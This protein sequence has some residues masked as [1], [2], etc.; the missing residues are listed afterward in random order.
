MIAFEQLVRTAIGADITVALKNDASDH[1]PIGGRKPLP[2]KGANALEAFGNSRLH[3]P[4]QRQNRRF[5]GLPFL[6]RQSGDRCQPDIADGTANPGLQQQQA[7]RDV[8]DD[9]EV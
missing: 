8:F 1:V 7:Q 2:V 5:Y 3:T 6:A 4:Q 9:S